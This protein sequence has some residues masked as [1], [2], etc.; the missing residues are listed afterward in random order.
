M[1]PL[2]V[3][4]NN[5]Y[6]SS[7]EKRA[8]VEFR[9][10]RHLEIKG[11]LR[12]KNVAIA[13]LRYVLTRLFNASPSLTTCRDCG[14]HGE[15]GLAESGGHVTVDFRT[16]AGRIVTTHHVYPTDEGYGKCILIPVLYT[17]I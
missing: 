6:R 2:Q 8:F 12:R 7:P 9:V 16:A 4:L 1:E 3:I 13:E 15:S 10:Q 14:W 17:D 5:V 11:F